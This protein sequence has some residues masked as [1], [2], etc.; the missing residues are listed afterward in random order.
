MTNPTI[1]LEPRR[2]ALLA[3]LAALAVAL[4]ATSAAAANVP[5]PNPALI[6][7]WEPC[8]PNTGVTV[9]VDDQQ[10][11]EGKIYVGCALGS[12]P[13]GVEA[14]EHAGFALE[15]TENY[16]LAFICR[17]D[18]E[19]TPAEQSCKTT[20]GT[21]A[22][23]SY[24][25]GKPGG[26][27]GYSGVGAASPESHSPINA[28][29]G[30][31]FGSHGGPRIQPMNGSGPSSF[32][33]PPEQESSM[34]PARL[35]SR[36][37]APTLDATAHAAE[38]EEAKK[39]LEPTDPELVL[40]GA[41]SLE[42][43]AVPA[44]E[45][46]EVVDWLAHGCEETTAT[47]ADG[48]PLRRLANPQGHHEEQNA[49]HFAL[50]VLGLQALAQNPSDFASI[51]LRDALEGMVEKTGQ[52]KSE[53]ES[54][55]EVEITAPT[56]RALART[57]TLS[58]KALKTLQLLLAKQNTATGTF[59][60]IT[61]TDV[62]AVQALVAARE[63]GVSVLGQS[64]L[65]AVQTAL[66]NAGAYLEGIQ[67]ADGG[68]RAGEGSEPR[69]KP[70][71]ESTALGAVGLA[72]TGRQ[73]ASERAARF[74]SR[75]QVT[76]EYA[77]EGNREAGEHTPAEDLIGA[78]LP[79]EGALRNALAF[80]VLSNSHGVF[81]EAQ[82]PTIDA[83]AA[84]LAAGPYGPFDAAFDESSLLFETSTVGVR[85]RPRTATLTNDDV[86][87]VTIS[88]AHVE[89]AEA[90]DFQIEA[91]HCSGH[92]LAPGESCEVSASF[93]PT[94][95]D[96]R[97]ALLALTLQGTSQTVEIPLTGTGEAITD[98]KT[99]G[100]P[101]TSPEGPTSTPGPETSSN[102]TGLQGVLGVQIASPVRIGGLSLDGLGDAHGLVGVSWRVL[103]AGAGVR[104]WTIAAK[105]LGAAG[106]YVNRLSGEGNLTT[107]LLKLPAGA[108]YELQITFTDALG[109]TITL[110][111]GRVVVP[112]DDRSGVLRYSGHWRRL[113]QAGAWLGTI[114]RGTSSDEVSLRL[115]A[116]RP[117]FMLRATASNAQVEVIAG[118]RRERFAVAGGV[119]G[120]LRQIT[121]NARAHAGTVGLRVLKG[122]VDVDGAALE[123]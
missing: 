114:S 37:L 21:G 53:G 14:L 74:V 41:V 38:A 122:T 47:T 67:E 73:A 70:S 8:E 17:I 118:S 5:N 105:A 60:G 11:G 44:S 26:V 58:A 50:A 20:P 18:G 56:V 69:F 48:C 15:G 39:T 87:P 75:Y 88:G 55:E 10:L 78:F 9:I 97:E 35:A 120:A 91:N 23:W 117:V 34:I 106:G 85:S 33:L 66:T 61:S 30:W 57:G 94:A 103:E 99:T 123:G 51:D 36:W 116:G 84:L 100:E 59:E 49:A 79:S 76:A 45:L 32:S 7:R 113:M 92:T 28:V 83:L 27:W 93:D 110:P 16:G 121:A 40:R 82:P 98:P 95:S 31:S 65:E 96:L 13:N 29:E 24:W 4:P 90:S 25:R 22:Y 102:N 64:T 19:P 101:K 52:V 68:V 46:T 3:V 112:Y 77:G 54:S 115:A 89:G 42:Q 43:A 72:L 86:R 71:V 111:I 63:Q 62:E 109:H 107:T 1:T 80:G 108:V 6:A 81:A 104:S 119:A 2:L 12:Q